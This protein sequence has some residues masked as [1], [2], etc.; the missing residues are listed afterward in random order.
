MMDI[1]NTAAMRSRALQLLALL[2]LSGGCH[3]SRL[4]SF[5]DSDRAAAA[6]AIVF[7]TLCVASDAADDIESGS[8]SAVASD[9]DGGADARLQGLADLRSTDTASDA[10]SAPGG[11]RATDAP[12]DAAV[13]VADAV[14]ES[15]PPKR[16]DGPTSPPIDAQ[17]EAAV[18]S[19]RCE[20]DT[21]LSC[22]VSNVGQCRLG[23]RRCDP[24]SGTYGECEGAVLPT[25]EVCDL[26]DNDCDNA[27]DEGTAGSVCN[28]DESPCIPGGSSRLPCGVSQVAPCRLGY[29]EC[30]PATRRYGTCTG[31]ILPTSETCDGA[32]NDCDGRTDNGFD[33]SSDPK[34]CGRCGNICTFPNGVGAC[35]EGSC[36]LVGCKPGHGDANKNPSDGCECTSTGPEVCDGVDNDCDGTIDYDVSG[37]TPRFLCTCTSRPLTIF[38]EDMSQIDPNPA[39]PR[40]RCAETTCK[41]DKDAGTLAMTYCL[42]ACGGDKSPWAVCQV[43]DSAD[44][45]DFDVDFGRA[46]I[47]EVVFEVVD[48]PLAGALR[49]YYGIHPRRKYFELIADTEVLQPGRHAR[50]F[51]PEQA[52]FPS[53]ETIPTGCGEQCGSCPAIKNDPQFVFDKT[54]IML[55]AEACNA[56]AEGRIK[57][58]SLNVLSNGCGCSQSADCPEARPRC[59]PPGGITADKPECGWP[60]WMPSGMCGPAAGCQTTVPVGSPCATENPSCSGIWRCVADHV[61][62]DVTTSCS[63]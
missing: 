22:G 49:L 53:W 15:A 62:C 9:A 40:T 39:P 13:D 60:A 46:G 61:I 2:F 31:A 10:D 29:R 27:I 5:S 3:P 23:V 11:D 54:N 43:S 50:Y 37:P 42:A 35:L 20:P 41:L 30:D 19:F 52:V 21:S 63:E 44:L 8:D 36:R 57:L 18:A 45:S 51:S 56:R 1:P 6:D 16:P 12:K 33:L 28:V 55:A 47:L 4:W 26:L 7:D 48:L 25:D 38:R 34:N 58:V 17:R 24:Q 59:L 32:D 14:A